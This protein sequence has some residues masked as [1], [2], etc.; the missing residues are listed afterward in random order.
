MNTAGEPCD[1]IVG[2][3]PQIATA[4]STTNRK[5]RVNPHIKWCAAVEPVIGHTKNK[6]R[7]EPVPTP[8]YFEHAPDSNLAI[9]LVAQHSTPL[10]EP[11]IP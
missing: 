7:T 8:T 2:R 6:H 10:P 4:H 1:A 9:N 3:M 11:A 5:R